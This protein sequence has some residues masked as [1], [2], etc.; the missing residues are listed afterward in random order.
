[1]Y[2]VCRLD[3]FFDGEVVWPM[4][5]EICCKIC[6][7]SNVTTKKIKECSND[8]KGLDVRSTVRQYLSQLTSSSETLWMMTLNCIGLLNLF[9]WPVAT[10]HS[11]SF[12]LNSRMIVKLCRT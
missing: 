3:R 7:A 4:N 8:F 2:V 12:M 9:L 11:K 6:S 10:A 1:M 5:Y